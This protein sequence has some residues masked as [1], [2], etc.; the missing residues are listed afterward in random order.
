[1]YELFLRESLAWDY[2]WML[3]KLLEERSPYTRGEINVTVST[4]PGDNRFREAVVWA[5]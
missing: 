1:M 4:T 5:L 2:E 3:I